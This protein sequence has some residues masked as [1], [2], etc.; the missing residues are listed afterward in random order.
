MKKL[1]QVAT[2]LAC[3]TL[4]GGAAAAQDIDNWRATDGTVWR[5][6]TNE[7]CWRDAFWTPATAAEGCDGA[8]I[9]AKPQSA[10]KPEPAPELVAPIVTPPSPPPAPVVMPEKVT[11]S[12]DAFFDFDK[13]VLKAEG[14]SKLDDLAAKV[15]GVSVDVILAVGHTDAIG[16]DAYNQGLSERRAAAVRNYLVS[17]G[18]DAARVKAEGMGETKPVADNKTRDGRAQNRRVEVEVTGTR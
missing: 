10:P 13:A 14:K 6:G 5:N 4:A 1:N 18:I 2:L 3:A 17:K 8:L 7:L 16:T 9:A 15:K 11:Y 12:A